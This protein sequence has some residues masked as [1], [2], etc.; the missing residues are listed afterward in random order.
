MKPCFIIGTNVLGRCLR[1]VVSACCQDSPWRFVSSA[2]DVVADEFAPVPFCVCAE[3]GWAECSEQVAALLRANIE[4]FSFAR[5][6]ADFHAIWMPIRNQYGPDDSVS[7]AYAADV[8]HRKKNQPP[9]TAA[10]FSDIVR[11]VVLPLSHWGYLKPQAVENVKTLETG[12]SALSSQQLG[13]AAGRLF[14]RIWCDIT[15]RQPN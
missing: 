1:Q 15:S 12:C 13:L 10:E 14:G 2:F 3:T 5:K 4:L 7:L 9:K 8:L 11:Q 6:A